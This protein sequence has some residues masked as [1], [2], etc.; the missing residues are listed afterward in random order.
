MRP[1]LPRPLATGQGARARVAC[2]KGVRARACSFLN[3]F[4]SQHSAPPW[5]APT[6]P[7][8]A[9]PAPLAMGFLPDGAYEAAHPAS[10]P[11]GAA[12]GARFA[13]AGEHE[14]ARFAAQF[15]AALAPGA[16]GRRQ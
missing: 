7:H 3:S 13:V 5:R 15:R 2:L 9:H 1:S 8:S 16:R 4:P 11:A 6:L 12:G 10:A 14:D